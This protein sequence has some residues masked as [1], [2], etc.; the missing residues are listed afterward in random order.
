[1]TAQGSG[2]TSAPTVVVTG[3]TTIR[4]FA[5]PT[6]TVTVAGGKVVSVI[7]SGAGSGFRSLPT[8]TLTGGGGVAI[9]IKGLLAAASVIEG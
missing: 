1:M 7:C 5:R 9:I 6:F 2:Y 8:L 4:G 3:G